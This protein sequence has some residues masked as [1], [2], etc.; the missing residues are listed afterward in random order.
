MR[1]QLEGE[2]EISVV[3]NGQACLDAMQTNLSDFLIL[4][5]RLPDIDGYD[6]CWQIRTAN[7]D[8]CIPII[9]VS[10][11]DGQLP[12]GMSLKDAI[13]TVD[14]VT[15]SGPVYY[16]INCAHPSHFTHVLRNDARW[17]DRIAGLRANASCMSHAELDEAVELDDGNPV[18]FGQSYAELNRLLNNL[19]VFGGCCGTDHR[20]IE[21]VCKSVTPPNHG[22]VAA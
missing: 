22:R 12:V 6:V 17:M 21:E 5:A 14:L 19:R 1:E 7:G 10:E 8:S 18:E 11:T 2:H 3:R 9:F 15:H 4:E 20:H 16:M 13:E